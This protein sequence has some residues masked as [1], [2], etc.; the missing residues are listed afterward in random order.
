M[1]TAQEWGDRIPLGLIYK[2]GRPS[3]DEHFSVLNRGP[4]VEQEFNREM[5]KEIMEEYA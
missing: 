3:F 5:L 1:K 2:N 4:L